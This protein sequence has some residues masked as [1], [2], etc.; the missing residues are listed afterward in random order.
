MSHQTATVPSPEKITVDGACRT[1]F[2]SHNPVSRIRQGWESVSIRTCFL[3]D[4]NCRLH[5]VHR[6]AFMIDGLLIWPDS[7]HKKIGRRVNLPDFRIESYP[8]DNTLAQSKHLPSMSLAKY[9]RKKL[10]RASF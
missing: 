1:S 10:N 5:E 6:L 9:L 3:E 4:S 2:G 8:L 7:G